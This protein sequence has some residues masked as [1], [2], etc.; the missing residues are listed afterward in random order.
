MKRTLSLLL[1]FSLLWTP[2][3]QAAV[4]GKS[5]RYVG[6]TLSVFKEAVNGKW[7]LTENEVI[8]A[9]EKGRGTIS[10]PYAKIETIEYGQKA[11]RRVG[12]AL[13]VNPLFLFSKKRKHFV[14]LSFLDEEGKKQGAVFELAKGI[15]K[16]SLTMLESKSGKKVEYESEEAKKYLEKQ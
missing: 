14:S 2:L 16:E 6:G 5:A 13:M 7:D 15:V 3:A 8:F 11:G 4:R 9:A 10:I 1:V 12:V